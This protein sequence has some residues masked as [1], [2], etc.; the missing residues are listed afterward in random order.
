MDNA[1]EGIFF[2]IGVAIGAYVI[3]VM[4]VISCISWRRGLR[5]DRELAALRQEFAIIKSG[6]VVTPTVAA[7]IPVTMPVTAS[8][9]LAVEMAVPPVEE[10][11]AAIEEV[12]SVIEDAP[13]VIEEPA[14]EIIPEVAS[15]APELIIPK[16]L[17]GRLGGRIYG[18]LG[19]IALALAGIFLV[20]H[21]IEQGWLS[22][23]V[24]VGLGILFGLVLLGVA[25]WMRRQSNN[26]GQALSAASMAV[27]Y[28]S[29]FS[30]VALYHLISP[31][32]AFVTLAALTFAAIALA[33]RDGPFVAL[34]AFAGGFLTPIFVSSDSPNLPALFIY[35]YLLQLGGLTL[36]KK[37]GWWYQAAIANAGGLLWAASAT[38][39]SAFDHTMGD[40]YTIPLFLIATCW[41]A[42]WAV[43]SHSAA[44][45]SV[46]MVWTT[47]GTSIACFILMA[48]LL[49]ASEFALVNWIFALILVFSHLAAA[50]LWIAED[51]PA[52]IGTAIIV[53][54]Y[55]LWPNMTWD[56]ASATV[57]DH[58]REII[59]TGVIFGA[60]LLFGGWYF[61]H[62][63]RHPTRWAALSTLG[64]AFIFGGAYWQLHHYQFLLSWPVLAITLAAIHMGL[65]QRLDY[66]RRQENAYVGAFAL[67]CL[68]VSGFI[69]IAI[70]MQL[71]NAWVPVA[72]SFELPVIAWVANRLDI[73]WLR[74]AI[75]IGAA[76]IL[77][78]IWFSNFPA[79]DTL[80]FNWLLYG[81]GLPM[82]S[83][84]VTAYL[85]TQ[86][87]EQKM[88]RVLQVLAAALGF[89]LLGFEID[90]FFAH[91]NVPDPDFLA[92][93][94]QAIAWLLVALVLI[95]IGD[96]R[97]A[98]VLYDAALVVAGIAG[99]WL[100]A[101]PLF[102]EHPLFNS[103]YVGET[104]FF[105]RISVVYG[106]PTLLGLSLAR[107]L[108]Q[109]PELGNKGNIGY[110]IAGIYGLVLGFITV[111]LLVRQLARGS[112]IMIHLPSSS[113]VNDGELY[114]Y[115]AAWTLYGV[116]L[117]GL[118]LKIRS[119]P[120]RYAS[121]VVVLLTVLKV[122]LIDAA[123]LTG[124]YRVASFLG[125]GV[126]LITIGYLYQRILFRTKVE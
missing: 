86:T 83:F 19:S 96:R 36:L 108:M 67:H 79:G 84:V 5:L 21:S 119:Q 78:G 37:R 53:A 11:P 98:P 104:A 92:H 3:L 125:L 50:R 20:K 126:A 100:L 44:V 94:V 40:T 113:P 42:I 123:D 110:R 16:D 23:A 62:G 52:Y 68:A 41:T 18:W 43:E 99:L 31:P 64:P 25:Q 85:L 66:L 90:H 106:L 120:L 10:V 76:L 58:S 112:D 59:G 117:L 97:Q 65:A 69:A 12:P 60:V 14:P 107:M 74:R 111:S 17:E 105:N 63:A 35:L 48:S 121:A 39:V 82:A 54:T 115:S 56:P 72:W 27:L 6:V 103:I 87:P 93:G 109:R 32:L 46:Q 24:R 89:A 2:L 4:P 73:A 28:A 102:L 77:G 8:V 49:M 15:T 26:L 81:L 124:L 88:R 91:I 70:P 101:F 47:R 75:W 22:P 61:I 71:E 30:A 9:E 45:R 57:I 13:P 95:P 29:L 33:L 38:M 51:I 118:G 80:I 55:A 1:I 34:V 7:P 122:G 116:A 114:G